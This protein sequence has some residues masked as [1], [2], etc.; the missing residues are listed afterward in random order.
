M[1]YPSITISEYLDA[2]R[3]ARL[4]CIHY[5]MDLLDAH[6]NDLEVGDDD[7]GEV[8]VTYNG[9]N[10]P[11]YASN[12]FSIVMRVYV[13]SD[14]NIV[15]ETEDCGAYDLDDVDTQDIVSLAQY[16]HQRYGE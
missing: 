7:Y 10:H 6:G 1:K 14:D 4:D 13:D 3:N 16:L 15:L 11:E 12:A 5:I 2:C 9:G 8:T